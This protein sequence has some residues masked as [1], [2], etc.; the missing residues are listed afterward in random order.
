MIKTLPMVGMNRTA[1][2]I[3]GNIVAGN[4][5]LYQGLGF[6]CNLP[7]VAGKSA[8]HCLLELILG[9]PLPSADLTPIAAACAPT[10]TVSIQ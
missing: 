8:I 4:Q 9:H 6:L 5:V 10:N 7:G 3:A 2:V 1:S